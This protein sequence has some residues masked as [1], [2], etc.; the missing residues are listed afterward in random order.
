MQCLADKRS[1]R[2]L[3]PDKRHIYPG[4]RFLGL[5]LKKDEAPAL[6]LNTLFPFE[7]MEGLE[8]VSYSDGD[9]ITKLVSEKISKDDVLGVDKM[10]A[11]RFL[12]PMIKA[13][14]ARDF[15]DGDRKSTRLNSSHIATSRMPSSA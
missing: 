1:D 4:E 9:D 15:V 14:I 11:A 10:L 6:F 13:G 2:D 3:L 7:E 12:L 8:I 5:L